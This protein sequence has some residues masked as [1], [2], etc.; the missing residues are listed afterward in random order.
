VKAHLF[1]GPAGSWCCDWPRREIR[2]AGPTPEAAFALAMWLE[3]EALRRAQRIN[4]A[5]V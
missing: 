2:T 4:N 5:A 3:A 1:R